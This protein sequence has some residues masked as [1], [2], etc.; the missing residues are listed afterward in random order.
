MSPQNVKPDAVGPAET[1]AIL[2]VVNG[3]GTAEALAAQI[4][5][6]NEPDIGLAL[7]AHI[8]ERRAELGGSFASLAELLTVKLLGP[9][10]FSRVVRA[11]LGQVEG[12]IRPEDVAEADAAKILAF[13]N[14]AATARELADGIEIPNEP[15]VGLQLGAH[16][17][18]RRAEL[19]GSFTSLDQV[20]TVKLIGPVRFTRI[21]RAILGV[22]D[23]GRDEFDDLVAQVRALQDA[24]A[25]APPRVVVTQVEPQRYLGQPMTIVVT[26]TGASGLPVG[27][28]PV[29]ISASWGR[30]AA[31]TAS[32]SRRAATSPSG[33]RAT[34]RHA[35]RSSRRPPRTS[36][37]R[38]RTRSRVRSVC[39]I[40]PPPRRATP[41]R[42][43]R[44]WWA[45]TGSRRTTTSAA[46]STSTSATSASTSSTASTT[47]TSST[48]GRRSTPPSSRT[49]TSSARTGR[50]NRRRRVGRARRP[51]PRLARRVAPTYT[52]VAA[53]E[54]ELGDEID[55]ATGFDDPSD[56]LGRIHLSVGEYVSL[57]N[58]VVGQRVGQIMADRKLGG[59]LESGIDVLPDDKQEILFPAVDISS[60]TVARL[61]VQALGAFEQTRTDLRSHVDTQLTTGIGAALEQ[62]E[63]ITGLKAQVAK[64]VDQSA[65]NSALASKLDIATLNQKLRD[66][67]DF[68]SFRTSLS[69]ALNIIINPG[70]IF[71]GP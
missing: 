23:I 51:C 68:G 62:S 1:A 45:S 53:E 42:A 2:A 31:P 27:G 7:A 20:L 19:G 9:V 34:E 14:A 49:S 52:D 43:S 13:L 24:I 15:D 35:R 30:F 32:R 64:K 65:F 63:T 16:I 50:R 29:T 69:N 57:Q 5:L 61:G 17:L 54:S 56:M 40:R 4:E 67:N 59:F 8:L 46:V 39:S 12:L 60:A 71:P 18:E 48:R 70:P 55:I 41:S 36:S 37:S 25:A 28:V 26:V 38:S 22:T 6:P 10:R 47:A 3:A 66:A 58:G 11:V 21:V 44:R 33:P